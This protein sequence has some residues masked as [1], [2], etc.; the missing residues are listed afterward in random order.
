MSVPPIGAYGFFVVL[1]LVLVLP[2][3]RALGTR[4]LSRTEHT[5]LTIRKDRRTAKVNLLIYPNCLEAL[6]KLYL[7]SYIY[8][9]IL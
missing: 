6:F 5:A 8:F 3:A 2:I 4:L 1:V 9:K 7:K